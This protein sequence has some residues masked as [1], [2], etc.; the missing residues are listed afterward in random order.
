MAKRRELWANLVAPQFGGPVFPMSIPQTM[1]G[2]DDLYLFVA[3]RNMK[4][5]RAQVAH[6]VAPTGTGTYALKNLTTTTDIS[7][8]DIDADALATDTAEAFAL[9]PAAVDVSEGDI[10]VLEAAG[11]GGGPLV[12]TL[13]V[14][15]LELKNS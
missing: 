13:E 4:V 6:T 12:V 9:D 3:T 7:S 10:V 1:S 5:R 14:E 15:F 11:T 8:A 2:A